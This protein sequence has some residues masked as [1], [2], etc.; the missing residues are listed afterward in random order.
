MYRKLGEQKKS[1][2]LPLFSRGYVVYTDNLCLMK[3]RIQFYGP[4]V[5]DFFNTLDQHTIE[6]I[7]WTIELIKNLDRIPNKY[8]KH[9]TGTNGLY[10]IRCEWL[11]NAIRLFCFFDEGKMIIIVHGFK[12]KTQKTPL[13]EIQQ[14]LKIKNEYYEEKKSK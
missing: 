2:F 11:R 6:K 8:F 3:R 14:A 13:K 1:G 9:L 5:L 4:R 12:K 10:E 7:E